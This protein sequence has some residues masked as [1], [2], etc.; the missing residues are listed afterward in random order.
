MLML[1]GNLPLQEKM[2]LHKFKFKFK[3]LKQYVFKF[4][5]SKQYVFKMNLVLKCFVGSDQ[6]VVVKSATNCTPVMIIRIKVC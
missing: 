4:K 3:Y 6:Q 5:Y 1:K 2:H